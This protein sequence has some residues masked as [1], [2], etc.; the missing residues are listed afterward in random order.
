MCTKAWARPCRGP[1]RRPAF[2][3]AGI[4]GALR[5]A[6]RLFHEGAVLTMVAHPPCTPRQ[7]EDD[8]R[9]VASS[10]ATYNSELFDRNSLVPSKGTVP[11]ATKKHLTGLMELKTGHGHSIGRGGG[12]GTHSAL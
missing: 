2:S 12:L 4:P 1:N 8:G 3:S 7:R 9:A 10:V 6:T 11:G 5:S